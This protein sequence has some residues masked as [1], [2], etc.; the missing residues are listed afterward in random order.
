MQCIL[1]EMRRVFSILLILS[2]GPAVFGQAGFRTV[3]PKDAVV[4]GDAFQVQ[5]I[6]VDKPAETFRPPAFTHFR[7]VSGPAVYK[8]TVDGTGSLVN[9]VFTL[10][11]IRPGRYVI[12]GGTLFSGDKT[13]RSNDAE[14]QVL[15][16]EEA[17]NRK[18]A[19]NE[20]FLRPGEDPGRKIRENLFVKVQV[21]KRTCYVGEPV[22]AIFKLYSRLQSRSD[23]VKNPG[24]YGFTVF[25][26]VNLSDK[27][28]SVE[29]IGG[30]LFDVHTVR[31]VQLFP[32]QSGLLYID[33][34]EVRNRV[35]FSR[36]AVSKKTEQ[37]IAE[38]MSVFEE[39]NE[40]LTAGS[41]VFESEMHTEAIPITVKPL[42]GPARPFP[43]HGAVGTFSIETGLDEKL[44]ATE[45]KGV[46]LVKIRGEGNFMQIDAPEL[47]W[48]QGIEVFE[49]KVSDEFDRNSYPLKGVRVFQYPFVVSRTG[50]FLIP[51]FQFHYFDPD[52]GMY[53]QAMAEAVSFRVDNS[54]SQKPEAAEESARSGGYLP[55]IIA[56]SGI[57][58]IG[59]FV[60]LQKARKREERKKPGENDG[61]L[62]RTVWADSPP[63]HSTKP[64]EF[65]SRLIKTIW[66]FL[67]LRVASSGGVTRKDGLF[68]LLKEKSSD[69]NLANELRELLE[70]CEVS[71]FSNVDLVEDKAGLLEKTRVL[72]EKLD[73]SL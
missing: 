16:V 73:R 23:I 42:P 44:L 10:E 45:H 50:A 26:Q 19:A 22:Q 11:A 7:L 47:K 1:R 66:R 60:F 25:D 61:E 59:L 31:K 2:A 52:S 3:V 36:N 38:G 62:L 51:A 33:E 24:F 30:K 9:M 13:L 49:P 14:V 70:T 48:P 40:M 35:E 53:H 63:A 6:V 15:S 18:E 20:Y 4:V 8:G 43:F 39:Q 68:A 64:A 34:M 21:D 56:A 17:A 37:E 32:L 54:L 5:Y 27:E 72:L 46:L 58:F 29:N 65:Y 67:E 69:P 55:W 28:S 57:L 12:R 41:E 71:M